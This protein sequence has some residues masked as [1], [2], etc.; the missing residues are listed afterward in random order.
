VSGNKLAPSHHDDGQ[1]AES[2]GATSRLNVN[3]ESSRH[4]RE[5]KRKS[6]VGSFG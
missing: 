1:L 2:G 6:I 3:P 4:L 5:V